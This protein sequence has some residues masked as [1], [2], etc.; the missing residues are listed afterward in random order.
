M[1]EIIGYDPLTGGPIW[2]DSS[3]NEPLPEPLPTQDNIIRIEV[4]R[5]NYDAALFTSSVPVPPSDPT[6][7][8]PTPPTGLHPGIELTDAQVGDLILTAQE[9]QRSTLQQARQKVSVLFVV[10]D[11]D[12]AKAPVY[13]VDLAASPVMIA[14]PLN[15]IVTV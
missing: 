11:T 10:D 3:L 4:V 9:W 6:A 14:D 12:E 7:P 15:P 8:V 1:A 13:T 5:P 2:D